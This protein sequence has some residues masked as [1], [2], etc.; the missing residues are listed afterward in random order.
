VP[1]APGTAIVE[2]LSHLAHGLDMT[3]IA[4]GVEGA[5]QHHALSAL[6]CDHLRGFHFGAAMAEDDLLA[7]ARSQ[8]HLH[9]V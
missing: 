6:H 7:L 3:V 9:A 5:E 2:S 4:D 1:L 8:L